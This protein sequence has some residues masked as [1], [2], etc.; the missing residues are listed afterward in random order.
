MQFCPI[1]DLYLL[2]IQTSTNIVWLEEM[3]NFLIDLFWYYVVLVDEIKLQ[4]VPPN[5]NWLTFVE[6]KIAVGII[7]GSY[8]VY[9]VQKPFMSYKKYPKIIGPKWIFIIQ[10]KQPRLHENET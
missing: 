1:V 10:S 4:D 6:N 3:P 2:I 8:F 9:A 5:K 7:H